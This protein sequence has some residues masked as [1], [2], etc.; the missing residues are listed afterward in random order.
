M[1]RGSHAS[2]QVGWAGMQ[3]AV[4]FVQEEVL[5]GF[6]LDRTLDSSNTFGK[7]FEDSFDVS[8]YDKQ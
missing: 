8:A 4:L 3:V 1:H 6:V 7:S 2:T 5:A